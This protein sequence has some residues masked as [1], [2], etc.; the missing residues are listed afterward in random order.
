MAQYALL[1]LLIFSLSAGA[2]SKLSVEK[3]LRSEWKKYNNGKYQPLLDDAEVANTVYLA[4]ETSQFNGGYFCVNSSKHFFIFFNGQLSGEY[5]GKNY[6][7]LDSLAIAYNTSSLIVSVYQ[8]NINA[9]DLITSIFTPMRESKMILDAAKPPTYFNDFVILAGL[10]ILVLF[11]ITI[12]SNPKLASDYL[13][14]SRI[15]SLRETEDAQSNAR[16]TSSSNLQFYVICSLLL[17]FYMIIIF[18][19]L[20]RQYALPLYF[21]SSGFLSTLWHWVRFS[22][23]I[24]S[25][26]MTKVL[27]IYALTRLFGLR[28]LA[29]IHFFNWMRLLLIVMGTSSIIL[30][31]YFISHGQRPE[32]FVVFLTVVIGT[33]VAWVFIVFLKLNGKTEHSMFHLFSYICATEIIPLLITIKVLFQ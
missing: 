15:F 20:P 18:H 28:G 24:L 11:L 29:R 2:Q 27:L 21:R 1:L 19:H 13:S 25:V 7:N 6:F 23:I 22:A 12:R 16:L 5:G 14:M 3:N 9:R 33:L 8:D 30:F 4:I 32:L 10:I 31:V 17:S 26:F